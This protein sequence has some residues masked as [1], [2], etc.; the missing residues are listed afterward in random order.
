MWPPLSLLIGKMV[1]MHC[2]H[3]FSC[4]SS[5]TYLGTYLSKLMCR[6]FNCLGGYENIIVILCSY[7]TRRVTRSASCVVWSDYAAI[8]RTFIESILNRF[9]LKKKCIAKHVLWL[10]STHYVVT[11]TELNPGLLITRS[12]TT[13][14]FA[15][16]TVIPMQHLLYKLLLMMLHITSNHFMPFPKIV[17]CSEEIG[18]KLEI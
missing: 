12:S 4:I 18:W 11:S 9:T 5:I 10:W 17:I 16:K 6:F 13:S 3:F 7:K 8:C 14:G 2:I 15:L 1:T